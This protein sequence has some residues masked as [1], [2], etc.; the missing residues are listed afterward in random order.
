M[1]RH[2][3][4]QPQSPASFDARLKARLLHREP[5]LKLADGQAPA[6]VLIPLA[7]NPANNAA[8]NPASKPASNPA[9]NTGTMR[10]DIQI[11]LTRRAA[12]LRRHAGQISF[13][14]GRPEPGDATLTDTALREAQE[15]IGIKAENWEV[16]GYLAPVQTSTGFTILPVLAGFKGSVDHLQHSWQADENEVAAIWLEDLMGLIAPARFEQR[17]YPPENPTHQ[18]W[19]VRDTTP[20]IWGATAAILKILSATLHA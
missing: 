11:L 8:N 1:T 9:I 14:G 10:D 6:S 17:A 15:E 20:E 4:S 12:H 13:P 3:D 5:R 2:P 16:L 7:A 19:V 18:V